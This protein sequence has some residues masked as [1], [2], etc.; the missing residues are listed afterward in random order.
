MVI[1]LI[2]SYPVA[3]VYVR[4][5]VEIFMYY[6]VL[7]KFLAKNCSTSNLVWLLLPTYTA[8]APLHTTHT[9]THCTHTHTHCAHTHTPTAHTHTHTHTACA[10]AHTHT[11]NT[12]TA[13]ASLYILILR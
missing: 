2:M 11:H 6:I 9:H 13:I 4:V 1:Q 7:L 8:S 10:R 3:S 12:V 5:I